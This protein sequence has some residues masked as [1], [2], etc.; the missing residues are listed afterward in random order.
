MF[1]ALLGWL[2]ELAWLFGS[3]VG[4]FVVTTVAIA[5]YLG[6]NKLDSAIG[7]YQTVSAKSALGWVA[8]V[9]I[10]Q[11]LGLVFFGENTW[12]SWNGSMLV[13]SGMAYTYLYFVSKSD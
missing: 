6:K 3:L 1:D 4:L 7:P 5:A 11:G 9:T 8:V 13:L 2:T 12:P 10:A